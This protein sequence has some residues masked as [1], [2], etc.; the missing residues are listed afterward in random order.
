MNPI[1]ERCEALAEEGWSIAAVMIF[2]DKDGLEVRIDRNSMLPMQEVEGEL[3]GGHSVTV[4]TRNLPAGV[5]AFGWSRPP[6]DVFRLA[7]NAEQA[8]VLIVGVMHEGEAQDWAC[9]DRARWLTKPNKWNS[10]LR[11]IQ[12]R[13][14]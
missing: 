11:R 12:G 6:Q 8:E 3:P 5:S 1:V 10:V 2:L 7:G 4:D 9:F 14:A 13:P